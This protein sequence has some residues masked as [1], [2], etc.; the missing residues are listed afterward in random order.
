MITATKPFSFAATLTCSNCQKEYSL[1]GINTY[2]VCCEQPL[3]VEYEYPPGFLKKTIQ[4]RQNNIWRYAEM[5]P[6]IEEKNIVSLGEG[7]TPIFPLNKLGD[8]YGFSD[9]LIKDESSNPTGSF[10]ARGLSVAVSKA[11]EFGITNCIIPTAGN[12]GGALAAYCAKANIKCTV[13]MPTHTP[14]IFKQECKLYGAEVILIDGLIND[15]AKKVMEI[16][17]H[18][19]YFDMSTLKEPY[20]LEGKKT[21]GYEIAEQLNWQ[22]PDV[23]IYPAGGGTGL[24]GIWKAFK[25][26]ISMGWISGPLPR[27]IAVQSKKCAPILCALKDSVTWKTDFIPE[28]TIANGLAVP[29]PFAM[30][31][32]LQVLNESGGTALAVSEAEIVAG[33]KEIARTE[34]LLISPEGA[35]TW[36]ALLHLGRNKQIQ[37][38]EKIL[39]LNTGSGYKYLDNLMKG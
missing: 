37:S 24:I 17:R 4:L 25:E 28:P 5:L 27:M 15:C 16:N 21:M 29:Y 10:K 33:V 3:V 26:M 8:Q 39:L 2:A 7:M 1:S 18:A 6:V 11:K 23:I 36:K 12:A 22:L 31:M 32:I 38:S 13:V 30:N 9:L 19:Q 14:A 34:G 20:R 35:A